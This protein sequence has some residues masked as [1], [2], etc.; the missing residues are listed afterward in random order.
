MEAHIYLNTPF[1][2]AWSENTPKEGCWSTVNVTVYKDGVQIGSYERGYPSYIAQTFCPFF[3]NGKW[4]ALY[5]ADYTC[6]RVALLENGRFEDWCGEQPSTWGF[7]PVELWVPQY[8]EDRYQT[9]G[10]TEWHSFYMFDDF[11]CSD[12]EF[13]KD[14]KESGKTIQFPPFGFVSGC[15]WG[16]DSSWKLRFIDLRGIEDKCIVISDKN[17]VELFRQ[18]LPIKE[19]VGIH[20]CKIT[21][22]LSLMVAE[23]KTVAIH[24]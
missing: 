6:T 8:Y 5:S 9:L 13:T 20:T 1:S 4:Y 14:A 10:S 7:C 11:E 21:E 24:L 3:L 23:R 2:I 22:Y 15:I 16:D 17:E 18:S 12:G 19:Q